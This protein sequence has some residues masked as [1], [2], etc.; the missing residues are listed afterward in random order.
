MLEV[1]STG[2]VSELGIVWT[3]ITTSSDSEKGIKITILTLLGRCIQYFNGIHTTIVRIVVALSDKII[4]RI[5]QCLGYKSKVGDS[6]AVGEIVN[7]KEG[8]KLRTILQVPL[9]LV[10]VDAI[11]LS[12]FGRDGDH[13]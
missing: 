6:G 9:S 13:T 4:V 12:E 3:T 10:G 5:R 1:P 2:F 8:L 11:A 7:V